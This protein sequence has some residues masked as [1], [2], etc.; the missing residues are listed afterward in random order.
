MSKKIFPIPPQFE[1][2]F[3]KGMKS[4]RYCGLYWT[5]SGDEAVFTNGYV[6]YDTSWIAYQ[7]YFQHPIILKLLSPKDNLGNSDEDPEKMLLVDLVKR[8]GKTIDIREGMKFLLQNNE[9]LKNSSFVEI[10]KRCFPN[11][12]D[13]LPTLDNILSI[14]ELVA[15]M[16]IE[17]ESNIKLM[18]KYLDNL[19]ENKK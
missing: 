19:L 10:N 9:I 5:P 6:T 7:M 1:D 3:C 17:E 8:T 14:D 2:L 15:A 11:S 18:K 4:D 16:M 12:P 13:S